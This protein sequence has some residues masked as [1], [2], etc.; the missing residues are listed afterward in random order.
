MPDSQISRSSVPLS[1]HA[2]RW[3]TGTLIGLPVLACVA[4]GPPWCL[5]LLLMLASPVALWEIHGLVFLEPIPLKW[6]VFSYCAGVLFPLGAFFWGLP[7][8]NLVLFCFLFGAFFLMMAC[9][10]RD[11]DGLQR[12]AQLTLAW[13]YVP[14]LLSYVLL[15]RAAPLGRY[16]IIFVLGVIIAGDAGAYHTGMRF[17]RH[18]LFERVSPKK[19]VEGAVGGLLASIILG[20]IIGLALLDGFH[21]AR[22]VLFSFF[23]AIVG[24]IGDLI[25]SMIKRNCG[26]KDAS[27]LLPGHGGL[28]D[29]LDSLLFAFPLMWFLLQRI[30]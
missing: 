16:W 8:L 6:R 4:A 9:S 23:I 25:E 12:I 22:I 11:P 28:L 10:P 14:Y 27:C 5:C 21:P 7:G 3:L 2:L 24:Q 15:L 13:F 30:A 20:T 29:R 26:K 1:P 18:K 17:G 19:T